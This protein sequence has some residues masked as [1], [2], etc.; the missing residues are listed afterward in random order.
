MLKKTLYLVILVLITVFSVFISGGALNDNTQIATPTANVEWTATAN[1]PELPTGTAITPDLPT[2]T[3]AVTLVSTATFTPIPTKT[4]TPVPTATALPTKTPTPT[5]VPPTATAVPM[6]FTVQPATPVYMVNFVHTT[7]G[8]NWQGVAGQVFDDAGNPL[9]NYV[10]KITGTYNGGSVNLLGVTGMVS[11]NPY[12]P[13]SYEIVLGNKA[14]DTID[15][16]SIQVFDS[17]GK[18]L[19]DPLKFST[20]SDCNKN[21]VIINF[22]EK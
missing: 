14:I 12:G 6:T 4:S 9:K 10:V 20:S 19:T 15:T 8:C 5:A 1:T 7:A 2:A 3:I 21:L 22:V 16:L 17:N 13:G 18:V 11:G